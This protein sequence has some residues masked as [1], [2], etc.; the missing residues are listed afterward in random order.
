MVLDIEL[1]DFE[2]YG[3]WVVIIEGDLLQVTHTGGAHG[4]PATTKFPC[5]LLPEGCLL[6]VGQE[7]QG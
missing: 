7:R 6:S 1:Q 4:E 2:F 5:I 3:V